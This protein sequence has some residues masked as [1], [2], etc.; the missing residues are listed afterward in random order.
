MGNILKA[1]KY[2]KA[3]FLVMLVWEIECSL[4]FHTGG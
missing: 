4:N 2:L 3:Y 1:V